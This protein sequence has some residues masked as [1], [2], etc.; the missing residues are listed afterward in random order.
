MN[1]INYLISTTDIVIACFF[2]IAIIISVPLAERANRTLQDETPES[3]SFMW[4][5]FQGY[6]AMIGGLLTTA[7][8]VY[9]IIMDDALSSSACE[10]VIFILGAGAAY[11]ALGWFTTKRIASGMLMLSVVVVLSL[12]FIAGAVYGWCVLFRNAEAAIPLAIASFGLLLTF[13]NAIYIKNRW[14]EL[15]GKGA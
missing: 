15:T 1:N 10:Y 5:Y 7:M 11:S 8:S 2:T 13:I 9:A 3:S 6:S 14:K 4:G 12:V